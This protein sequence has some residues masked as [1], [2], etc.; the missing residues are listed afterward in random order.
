MVIFLTNGGNMKRFIICIIALLTAVVCFT[1]CNK[2]NANSNST[3]SPSSESTGYTVEISQS[4]VTLFVGQ[5]TKLE[6]IVSKPNVY[7]FWSIQDSSIAKVSAD[8]TV[9]ALAVG[10]TICYAKFGTEEAM[11]LIKV[12][13]Q[14]VTPMLSVSVAHANDSIIMYLGEDVDVNATVRLGDAVVENVEFEYVVANTEVLSVEDGVIHADAVGT[15]TILVKVNYQGQ[16]TSVTL[17]VTVIEY[18]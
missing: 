16:E 7:V 6:A 2:S 11:C 15:S 9:T 4:E 14:Q 10:Q 17:T 12:I 13:P 5:T 18:N 1:A 3:S 8:G